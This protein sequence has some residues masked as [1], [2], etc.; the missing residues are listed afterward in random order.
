MIPSSSVDLTARALLEVSPSNFTEM[1][2]KKIKVNTKMIKIK[3]LTTKVLKRNYVER[4][5]RSMK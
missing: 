1:K 5:K 2:I 3:R 4:R